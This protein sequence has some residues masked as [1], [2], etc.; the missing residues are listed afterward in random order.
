M[1]QHAAEYIRT[2]LAQRSP[3]VSVQKMCEDCNLQKSTIDK[4][5]SRQTFDTGWN[6][7]MT[8]VK[9]LGGSLD[10]L[11]E[12]C[13]QVVQEAAPPPASAPVPA[14]AAHSTPSVDALL[15]RFRDMHTETVSALVSQHSSAISHMHEQ[16]DAV[17]AE[18]QRHLSAME[19]GRNFWRAL[20][21]ALI[22]I[23]FLAILWIVWE[24]AHFES[25]LTGHFLRDL[26]HSLA[27]GGSA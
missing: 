9:Y 27:N 7:V 8:M 14:S 11:A 6:N 23:L 16:C 5:L 22:G 13:P 3:R 18:K 20:A 4:F 25:G 1:P 19:N 21:C 12:I 15:D 24:F 17:C 10:H 2:L 26:M